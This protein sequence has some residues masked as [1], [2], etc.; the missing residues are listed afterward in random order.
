MVSNRVLHSPSARGLISISYCFMLLRAA[1]LVMGG[2]D[3]Q[4][5]FTVGMG[6][7]YSSTPLPA[8]S[9]TP[10]FIHHLSLFFYIAVKWN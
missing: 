10:L 3:T 8:A 7:Y 9:V 1:G 4:R 5:I 2:I 6:G